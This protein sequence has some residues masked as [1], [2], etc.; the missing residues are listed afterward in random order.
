MDIHLSELNDKMI[1]RLKELKATHYSVAFNF[2]KPN[3]NKASSVHFFSSDKKDEK[4]Y[5]DEVAYFNQDFHNFTRGELSGFNEIS[6][7][8]GLDIN[9]IKSLKEG[10]LD[11][12]AKPVEPAKTSKPTKRPKIK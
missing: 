4:G 6:R 11:F 10:G 1:D 3:H 7:K 5:L 2:D 8:N 9:N 12:D